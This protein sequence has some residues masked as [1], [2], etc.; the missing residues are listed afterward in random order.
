MELVRLSRVSKRPS[1]RGTFRDAN[2]VQGCPAL[3]RSQ[4]HARQHLIRRQAS[5]LLHPE[6][7]GCDKAIDRSLTTF[8]TLVER[9]RCAADQRQPVHQ[10]EEVIFRS[11]LAMGLDLLQAFLASPA[12]ATPGPT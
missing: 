5:G 7:A 4:A 6:Q 3:E 8:W 10:V 11:L 9:L 12:M 1:P 2:D